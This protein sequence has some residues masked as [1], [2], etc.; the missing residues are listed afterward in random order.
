MNSTAGTAYQSATKKQLKKC[1]D[2]LKEKSRKEK[3]ADSRE[4]FRTGGGSPQRSEMTD[5]LQRLGAVAS[6]MNVRVGNCYDSDRG[7]H[8]TDLR[9]SGSLTPAVMALLQATQEANGGGSPIRSQMTD[10]LQRVGAVAGHMNARVV[11]IYDSDHGRHSTD[12]CSSDSCTPAVA[13]L[14]Q[15]TQDANGMIFK[16]TGKSTSSA[17]MTSRMQHVS[18]VCSLHKVKNH[19][20]ILQLTHH[21][22]VQVVLLQNP[23]L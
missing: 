8:G 12:P 11:N 9:N 13:A 22:C 1:W 3:A 6:H 7:R 2:N 23:Q 21:A 4:V 15:E 18:Q 10:E 16:L 20:A 19:Q 14:L 17:Q 5:E